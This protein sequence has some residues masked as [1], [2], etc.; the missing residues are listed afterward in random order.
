MNDLDVNEYEINGVHVSLKP[1]D[2]GACVVSAD[3]GPLAED[4]AD[5]L[6]VE[7]LEANYAF[8]GAAGATLSVDPATNHVFLR[9]RVWQD[10]SD[11][12]AVLPEIVVFADKAREWQDRMA[13]KNFQEPCN[14][15][16]DIV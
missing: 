8:Q 13:G 9:K 15:L 6:I 12:D 16:Y 7:M 1:G 14:L 3:L 4:D 2:G 11:E 10:D 5:A